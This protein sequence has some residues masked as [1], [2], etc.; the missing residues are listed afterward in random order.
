[1][2]GKWK[3][4]AN[5]QKTEIDFHYIGPKLMKIFQIWTKMMKISNFWGEIDE[6]LPKKNTYFFFS[7]AELALQKAESRANHLELSLEA[8]KTSVENNSTDQVVKEE[9]QKV[10]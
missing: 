3:R 6:I 10:S 1:M 4:V 5:N 8:N 9:L 2:G 7:D